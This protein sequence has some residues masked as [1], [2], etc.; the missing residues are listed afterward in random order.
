MLERGYA[1]QFVCIV[2]SL[3]GGRLGGLAGG[4]HG[5]EL[6]AEVNIMIK[7]WDE[8]RPM[9]CY[10]QKTVSTYNRELLG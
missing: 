6:L 8:F 10:V 7:V 1:I 4:I 2:S 5:K 3:L 9:I